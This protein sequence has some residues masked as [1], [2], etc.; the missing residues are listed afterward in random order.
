MSLRT[1]LELVVGSGDDSQVFGERIDAQVVAP[2]KLDALDHAW[3]ILNGLSRDLTVGKDKMSVHCHEEGRIVGEFLLPGG[4]AL[5][6]NVMSH[7][8]DEASHGAFNGC[9]ALCG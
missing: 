5:A 3:E 1:G 8:H 6:G 2:A 9:F 7:V 4:G